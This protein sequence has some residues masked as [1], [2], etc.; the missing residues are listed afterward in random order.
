MTEK[1]SAK[2]SVKVGGD[3]ELEGSNG[4]AVLP[5]GT[6][7]TVRNSY[8]VRHAGLHVIDGVEYQAE[9]K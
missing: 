7:V 6:A 8:R 1:K 4:I 9:D 5:D 3:I 2:K